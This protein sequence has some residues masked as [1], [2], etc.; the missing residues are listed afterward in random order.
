MKK[1]FACLLAIITVFASLPL[2]SALAAQEEQKGYIKRTSSEVGI[3]FIKVHE[4]YNQYAYWDYSQYTIGYGTR[5]EKD[6]YP[7]GISEPAAHALLKKVLPSYENG[8]N[9]FLK[10]NNIYVTQNQFDA[11]VSFSYNFGAYVLNNNPTIAKYLKNGIE[12]YT[13]KQIA[14]A[15]GLW[16][17]A[18][19][20]KLQALV[21]RRAAE[22]ALFCSDDY[23]FDQEVYVISASVNVRKGPGT[24]YGYVGSLKRGDIVC[25]TNKRYVGS[26][27]WGKINYQNAERWIALDYARYSD[28]QS[29]DT[30]SLIATCLYKTENTVN[31]IALY[32]KKVAGADGYKIYKKAEGSS[33]YLL[34]KNI[35]KKTTASYID[36]DVSKKQ[37]TYYVVAYKGDQNAEKSGT[38]QIEFVDSTTLKSLTKLANGFKLTWTKHPDANSYQV[39]RAN[40]SDN[41]FTKIATVDSS[42]NSYSD[43]SAVGGITYYYTVKAVTSA[44]VSGAPEAKSGMYLATPS[45]QSASNTKTSITIKWTSSISAT[46]YYVSRKGPS[47]KNIKRIANITNPN[48]TTYTDNSVANGTEYKY[49]VRAYSP[50]LKSDLSV[51]YPTKIYTPPTLSSALSVAD[52]VALSWK[53]V[54]G[55]PKYNVYRRMSGEKD[56][57]LIATVKTNSYTDTSAKTGKKYFYRLTSLSDNNS[58]SYRSGYKSRL[59]LGSTKIT[60]ASAV[61]SGLK[62]K[63]TAVSGAVS[64]SIYKYSSGKYTLL[65]TVKTTS[66]TDKTLKVDKSRNYAIKV[67]FEKTSSDYSSTFKAYRLK[68]PTLSIKNTKNGLLLSWTAVKNATGVIIYRKDPNSNAYTLYSTQE[69]YGKYTFENSTAEK[70]KTY[71]YKI[72]VINGDSVSRVSNAVTKKRT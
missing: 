15:F 12:K 21:E 36:T 69:N 32:W 53:A 10:T 38:C 72:Y 7:A 60:S 2:S 47:D 49:Y 33:G 4:G 43:T 29:K 22:A 57:S 64:Y 41:T 59:H 52:G 40:A 13:D 39:L 54:S 5:C 67:N 61:K 27:V 45:I 18:G 34:I 30:S 23:T 50:T 31:G 37:Y 3:N 1:F 35:T 65:S 55:V 9:S 51:A 71:S 11:L 25:I 19:G 46:A 58:E 42:L 70:G 68:K 48:I 63:W 56:F 44:G 14:D 8:V 66:Y 26:K 62:L 24:S 28:D 17:N 6:E 16:V 20:V